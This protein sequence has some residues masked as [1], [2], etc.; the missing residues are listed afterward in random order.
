MHTLSTPSPPDSAVSNEHN[1]CYWLLAQ[2]IHDFSLLEMVRTETE[3][4]WQI[5]P[6]Q[7]DSKPQLDIKYLCANSPNLASIFNEV[8]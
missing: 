3:A 5:N 2:L 1:S 7:P 6:D 8:M 4:A